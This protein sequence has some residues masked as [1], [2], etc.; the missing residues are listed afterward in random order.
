MNIGVNAKA[1]T[2]TPADAAIRRGHERLERIFGATATGTWE[3]DLASGRV[4][5][6]ARLL[7][8]LGL[9]DDSSVTLDSAFR[10]VHA[11]DRERVGRGVSAAIAREDGGRFLLEFRVAPASESQPW[12]VQMRG[13]VEFDAQGAPRRLLGT[14]VDV[15][16]LKTVQLAREHNA[17]KAIAELEAILKSLPDALY[18][19]DRHGIRFANAEALAMLGYH[20]DME[21]GRD[22]GTLAQE[23]RTRKVETGEPIPAEGQAFAHALAGNADVQE[24]LIRHLH[25]G[26]DRVV[27]CASSPIRVGGKVVGAVAINTDITEKKQ[28]ERALLERADF[29]KLLIG[30]VSHDLRNPLAAI[31]LGTA[32]ILR[33]GRH[34][35]RTVTALQVIQRSAERASRLVNDLLDFTQARLGGA[36]P[37]R[38]ERLDFGEIV[39]HVLDE[40]QVRYPTR[41]LRLLDGPE[42]DMEGDPDRLAQIVG[43]LVDNALKYS[44]ADTPVTVVARGAQDELN[45]LTL[46]VHNAGEPISS[47]LLSRLFEP[48]RRGSLDSPAASRSVGLGLYIVSEIVRAHRG[49]ID[50]DS[51]PEHGTTFSVR[52]PRRATSAVSHNS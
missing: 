18:V 48:M 23:I 44:P 8:L 35:E 41:E 50:C 20:S 21:L 47:E 6:D 52:L 17:E 26:Q 37:I 9:P 4:I 16:P 40:T 51:R 34:D 31:M 30:I 2:T 5:T 33:R 43:N 22:I 38:H 29:E 32:V 7:R 19:G 49:S 12:W 3:I 13:R 1:P 10:H 36:I 15:T 27:R 24:V 11:L 25:T 42:L 14:A 39:R 45:E 46:E 28:A